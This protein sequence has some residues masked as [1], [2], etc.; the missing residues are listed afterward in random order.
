M[1]IMEFVDIKSLSELHEFFHYAK[2]LHPL[3]SVV[4][5]SKVNRSHRKPGVAYR[6]NLYAVACKEILSTGERRMISP[7]EH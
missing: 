5:L 1:K 3:I 6:L 2:P 7:K 4:D